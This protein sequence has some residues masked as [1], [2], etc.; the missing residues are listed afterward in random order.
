MGEIDEWQKRKRPFEVYASSNNAEDAE[1]TDLRD[2]RVEI[3]ER[4]RYRTARDMDSKH[5]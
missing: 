5:H 2:D 4:E 3:E 1:E